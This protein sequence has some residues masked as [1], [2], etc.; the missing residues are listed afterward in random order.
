MDYANVVA[1]SCQSIS[2]ETARLPQTPKT[3]TQDTPTIPTATPMNVQ[4][5]QSPK[6]QPTPVQPSKHKERSQQHSASPTNEASHDSAQLPHNEE[7]V[8][9]SGPFIA[10]KRRRRNIPYFL[11]NIDSGLVE[12][13]VYDML[14]SKNVFVSKHSNLP[15]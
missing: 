6:Q 5:H 11:S 12:K 7:Y 4:K 13:D 2:T 1:H 15:W 10:A 8:Q 9:P 14:K 3:L